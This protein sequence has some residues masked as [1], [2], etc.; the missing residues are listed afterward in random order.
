MDDSRI[1]KWAF[2][3]SV[4]LILGF[5]VWQPMLH[6]YPVLVVPFFVA[7]SLIVGSTAI[8][9]PVRWI[10]YRDDLRRT[11]RPPDAP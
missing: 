8:L 9:L 11:K 2:W 7:S 5:P 3:I 1:T 6:A 10:N 4:S